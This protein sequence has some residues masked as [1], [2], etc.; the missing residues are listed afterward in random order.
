MAFDERSIIAGKRTVT[1]ERRYVVQKLLI[2]ASLLSTALA[3]ATATGVESPNGYELSIYAALPWYFWACLL[4]GMILGLAVIFIDISVTDPGH[5]KLGV[6]AVM[7]A[8]VLLLYLPLIR[9]YYIYGR[10]DTIV[11][12]TKIIHILNNGNLGDTLLHYPLLHVFSATTVFIT[13]ADP[14]KLPLY[15]RPIFPLFFVLCLFLLLRRMFETSR[16]LLC[17]LPFVLVMM[18]KNGT[19]LFAPY[20]LAFFLSPLLLYAFFNAR[21]VGMRIV[22]GGTLFTGVMFHPVNSL[23]VVQTLVVYGLLK[24]TGD[25]NKLSIVDW[26]GSSIP[27]TRLAVWSIILAGMYNIY[28]L[29]AHKSTF[30]SLRN[31]IKSYLEPSPSGGTYESQVSS[32]ASELGE[33][34][35]WDIVSV[36]MFRQGQTVLLGILSL[37][38]VIAVFYHLKNRD[39][40]TLSGLSGTTGDIGGFND[41]FLVALY[42]MFIAETGL[43]LIGKLPIGKERAWWYAIPLAGI[44]SGI[45]LYSLLSHQWFRRHSSAIKSVFFIF[46]VLT[47]VFS[48]ANVFHSP[49]DKREPYH[50]PETEIEATAWVANSTESGTNIRSPHAYMYAEEKLRLTKREFTLGGRNRT[51]PPHFRYDRNHSGEYLLVTDLARSFYPRYYPNYPSEWNYGPA[52]FERLRNDYPFDRVYSNGKA[53]V[54]RIEYWRS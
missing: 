28:W 25:W 41:V 14:L 23:L 16:K 39:R 46:L 52:D 43:F 51:P 3:G 20:L 9:G 11:H 45:G 7:L 17:I 13:G 30:S 24:A 42:G 6:V 40:S 10:Y 27:S 32:Y 18:Y 50:V 49:L 2:I 21:S 1:N 36:V 8:N 22:L 48:V 35:I 38:G 26:D 19:M 12:T 54:Y 53:E 31:I 5:W 34:Q 33:A 44:V 15:I 37:V 29:I 47:T 4:S